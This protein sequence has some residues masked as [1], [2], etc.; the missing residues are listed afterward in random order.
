MTLVL[1]RDTTAP[2]PPSSPP[3]LRWELA[4]VDGDAARCGT[5]VADLERMPRAAWLDVGRRVLALDDGAGATRQAARAALDRALE[6]R[7]LAVSAWLVRDAIET[8]ACVAVSDGNPRP[9]RHRAAPCSA[10]EAAALAAARDAAGLAALAHL[11]HAGLRRDEY[12]VLLA[13]FVTI[14]GARPA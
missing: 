4:A 14:A 7:R 12:L 10:R 6:A 8:L 3:S 11:A 13:P 2:S 1:V 9:R 5:F